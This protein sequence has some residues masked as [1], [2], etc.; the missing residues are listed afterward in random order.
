MAIAPQ[1][2]IAQQQTCHNPLLKD[3]FSASG[4]ALT[5]NVIV[6]EQSPGICVPA[7]FLKTEVKGGFSFRRVRLLIVGQRMRCA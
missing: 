2:C 7:N 1:I 3:A 5:G 4:T 6:D